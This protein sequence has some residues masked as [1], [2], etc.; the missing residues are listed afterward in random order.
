MSRE[1]VE[2]PWPMGLVPDSFLQSGL[3]AGDIGGRGSH[4][5]MFLMYPKMR[6]PRHVLYVLEL[7]HTDVV[8][9]RNI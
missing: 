7:R 5:G 6:N 9:K 2:N 8:S 1:G 4:S 3:E